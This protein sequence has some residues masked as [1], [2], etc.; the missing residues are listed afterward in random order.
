MRSSIRA[1]SSFLV[2]ICS[3]F[4]V[5]TLAQSPGHDT[6]TGDLRDETGRASRAPGDDSFI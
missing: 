2:L 4:F 1:T 5:V 6:V 3:S